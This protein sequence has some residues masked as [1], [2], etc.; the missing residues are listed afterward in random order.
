[1]PAGSS[2]GICACSVASFSR[3]DSG[4]CNSFLGETGRDK[5]RETGGSQDLRRALVFERDG[6]SVGGGVIASGRINWNFSV[7]VTN[8]VCAFTSSRNA[9]KAPS[10]GSEDIVTGSG[11][12]GGSSSGL[13]VPEDMER[14]SAC[15]LP[16]AT[17]SSSVK[18]PLF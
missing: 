6:D 15:R 3:I 7:A 8:I 16:T 10:M 9:G 4:F 2:S 18:V 17:K 11:G 14:P 1:V 12:V 5:D 13:I